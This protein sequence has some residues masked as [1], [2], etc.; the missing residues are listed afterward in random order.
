MVA[1]WVSIKQVAVNST[2]VCLW[3]ALFVGKTVSLHPSTFTF[4]P[5]P[6]LFSDWNNIAFSKING[7]N[8]YKPCSQNEIII[9]FRGIPL[10]KCTTD[11]PKHFHLNKDFD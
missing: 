3:L 2:P 9:Y 8:K 5:S 7:E 11:Q 6:S 4:H 10:L 1:H